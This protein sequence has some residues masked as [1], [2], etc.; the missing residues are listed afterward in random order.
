[1]NGFSLALGLA[2]FL[3]QDAPALS[4]TVR[5]EIGSKLDAYL[6]RLEGFGF[7]GAALAAKGGEILLAKGYGLADREK[8]IPVGVDTVFTVG[9]ITK[10]FTAAAILKLEAEGKLSVTDPISKHLEGVPE[11]KKG[12]TLHHLLTHSAGLRSDFV[13]TDFTPVERDEYV[14]RA[15]AS[16]LLFEPGASYAY[17]NSGYSLLGAIVER[18]TGK[19]YEAYLREALFEPA[20]MEQTGYLLPAW[21]PENLAQGYRDGE[22][23]GTVL[24]RPMASDGPY[25]GLRA[26]GGI[27][28]TLGDMLRWHRAL[29][30]DGVLQAAAREKLFT[31]YVAEDPQGSSH[32]GYGWAIF[33][34]KRGTK[35]VAHNGGNGIFAADFHRYLDEDAV[36]FLASSAEV[37]AIAVSDK[38]AAILFGE[39]VPLP[40]EVARLDRGALSKFAGAYRLPGGG[41]ILV[42][43]AGDA[44]RL[45]AEDPGGLALLMGAS[46]GDVERHR[47]KAAQMEA[48]LRGASEG[49]YAPLHAAL[50]GKMPLEEVA[51]MERPMWETWREH[52]GRLVMVASFGRSGRGGTVTT[53]ARLDFERG[54]RFIDYVWAGGEVVDIRARRGSPGREVRPAGDREFV[55]FEP[56]RSETWRARFDLGADGDVSALAVAAGAAEVL[57]PRER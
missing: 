21:K 30:G 26:N 52:M 15:L 27:H 56:S 45:E 57:C 2:A 17:A 14:R 44:L 20:G 40:P 22:K 6:S 39:E 10:Q 54:L 3:A 46:P 12:I 29:E 16:D 51:S 24:G 49:N 50:G 1:M 33:R 28:S 31:P 11:D 4:T 42:A 18:L 8:R 38:V 13:E 25:W 53:T 34:T 9:S 23:W 55:S 32:Y 7:S 36:L 35:L 43:V 5:G 41:R 19:S 37:S 47:A 48:V